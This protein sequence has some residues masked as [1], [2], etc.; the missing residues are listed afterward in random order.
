MIAPNSINDESAMIAWIGTQDQYYIDWDS[1]FRTDINYSMD[2]YTKFYKKIN[3][4]RFHRV[5]PVSF[6]IRFKRFIIDW[7]T[8][9]VFS[10]EIIPFE[11]L[12]EVAD[13]VDWIIFSSN[14]PIWFN[15][16]H[17][18]HFRNN[19][20]WDKLIDALEAQQRLFMFDRRIIIT[21]AK[22]SI[23]SLYDDDFMSIPYVNTPKWDNSVS[24]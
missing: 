3:W 1:V 12:A 20:D 2:F 7:T 6:L 21:Y 24:L 13:K 11:L 19:I 22:F 16:M 5:M 9:I 4:T 14:P 15:E 10:K 17:M 8:Q 18:I 23:D